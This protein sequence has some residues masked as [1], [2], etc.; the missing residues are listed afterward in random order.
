MYSPACAISWDKHAE[1]ASSQG[2]DEMRKYEVGRS[3]CDSRTSY[4]N[5]PLVIS[6][7][8][9]IMLPYLQSGLTSVYVLTP[10]M[11]DGR[12]IHADLR[13][14]SC[15]LRISDPFGL[16]RDRRLRSNARD[17]R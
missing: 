10:M 13:P 9:S 15:P 5:R 12:S 11:A 3:L 2:C 1:A 6:F 16:A 14:F 17:M 7:A 8:N 4:Y